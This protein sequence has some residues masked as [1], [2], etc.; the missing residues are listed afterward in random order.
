[1]NDYLRVFW[2]FP[3]FA[4][5]L[6]LQTFSQT[7]PSF[8]QYGPVAQPISS[9]FVLR[10]PLPSVDFLASALREF[11]LTPVGWRQPTETP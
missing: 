2:P 4:K 3:R 5:Q 1:M 7:V 11:V 8:D 10:I 6:R 9:A